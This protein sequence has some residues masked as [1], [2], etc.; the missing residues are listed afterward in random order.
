M[1]YLVYNGK[2]VTS[3]GKYVGKWVTEIPQQIYFTSSG[4]VTMDSI[5][6]VT[7]VKTIKWD[8]RLDASV[9]SKMSAIFG[10][11][12]VLNDFLY[13]S[14]DYLPPF[15]QTTTGITYPVLRVQVRNNS[16][17]PPVY[18]RIYNIN[19]Y[20]GI[21]TTIEIVKGT[22]N[23]T[24]VKANNN[25][26][27]TLYSGTAVYD[28]GGNFKEIGGNGGTS[29]WNFE[30]TGVSK[31]IGYPYGNQDSA[32]ADTIDSNNGTVSG[33]PGTRNLL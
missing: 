3:E 20:I 17:S 2:R 19:S 14:Y 4:K 16:P 26:L 9:A 7:G 22:G 6:D 1:S 32:W 21:N 25:T 33:S 11:P 13:V 29:I 27:T 10:D 24:S 15:E 31:W 30:I 23:L 8:M 18:V 12:T 28:L 5:P